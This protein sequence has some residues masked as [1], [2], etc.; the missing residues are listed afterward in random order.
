MGT[1][2]EKVG[3]L[4]RRA[5]RVIP[6]QDRSRIVLQNKGDLIAGRFYV[7][8][9]HKGVL[10]GTMSYDPATATLAIESE[11]EVTVTRKTI[12]LGD[13]VLITDRKS[14]KS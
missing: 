13:G 11:G 12:E 6:S 5:F 7:E 14:A 3:S 1:L 4:L 2:K 9:A 8:A 10:E